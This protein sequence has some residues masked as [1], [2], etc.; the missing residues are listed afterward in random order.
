M[1]LK[2][3]EPNASFTRRNLN[4]HTHT[5]TRTQTNA[6]SHKISPEDLFELGDSVAPEQQ[7]FVLS[8]ER[9]GVR[10]RTGVHLKQGSTVSHR[11]QALHCSYSNDIAAVTTSHVRGDTEWSNEDGDRN[12]GGGTAAVRTSPF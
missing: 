6:Q 7:L 3:V 9:L 2:P 12:P 11:N 4:S 10:H 8:E 1:F 5:N